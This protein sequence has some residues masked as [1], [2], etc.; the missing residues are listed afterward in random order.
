VPLA[1]DEAVTQRPVGL[2]RVDA[3]NTLEQRDED[4]RDGKVPTHMAQSRAADRREN[5]ATDKSASGVQHGELPGWLGDVER[6]A[7][8]T[9]VTQ[10]RDIRHQGRRRR[11]VRLHIYSALNLLPP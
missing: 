2:G 3:Q 11:Q 4:V 6:F 1:E 10:G 7:A 8:A 5:P 9:P